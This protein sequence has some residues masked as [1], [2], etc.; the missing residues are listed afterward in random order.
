MASILRQ[1][2]RV[3]APLARPTPSASVSRG[4]AFTAIRKAGGGPPQLL[5]PGAKSGEV[6]TE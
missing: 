6:P 3:A 2:T 4:F 1:F 5:G